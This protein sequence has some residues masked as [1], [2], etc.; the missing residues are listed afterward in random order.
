MALAERIFETFFPVNQESIITKFSS[1]EK[2]DAIFNAEGD[3]FSVLNQ[4]FRDLLLKEGTVYDLKFPHT[5]VGNPFLTVRVTRIGFL[6]D[7]NK[8]KSTFL[9]GET[10]SYSSPIAEGLYDPRLGD[11]TIWPLFKKIPSNKPVFISGSD[12][13]PDNLT[14]RVVLK[15]EYS[16]NRLYRPPTFIDSG[17]AYLPHG[18]YGGETVYE[19]ERIREILR[20][21]LGTRGS[22]S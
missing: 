20:G 17:Y 1:L 19:G 12:M 3:A 22:R 5:P 7:T 9:I 10:D 16:L 18:L 21:W 13:G 11:I 4:G 2:L 8:A 15:R 14:P 6:L